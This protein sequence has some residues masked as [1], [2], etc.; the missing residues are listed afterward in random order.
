MDYQ[1]KYSTTITMSGHNLPRTYK[2]LPMAA[3]SYSY[4]FTQ[5][6]A[7]GKRLF[8]R[9][10]N[11]SLRKPQFCER[12]TDAYQ[13]GFDVVAIFCVTSAQII[14]KSQKGMSAR[15]ILFRREKS[16]MI[17]TSLPAAEKSSHTVILPKMEACI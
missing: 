17:S 6:Q 4:E 13:P 14:F 15:C 8:R 12:I 7:I 9:V 10:R 11:G 16:A 5:S 1:I 3:Q 2:R